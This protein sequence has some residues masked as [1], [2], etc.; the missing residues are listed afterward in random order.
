MIRTYVFLGIPVS[1]NAGF[2]LSLIPV[3]EEAHPP[4]LLRI[5]F[6]ISELVYLLFVF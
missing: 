1:F 5:R 6:L 4:P 2:I 3:K